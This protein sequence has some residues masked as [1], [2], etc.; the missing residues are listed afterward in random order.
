MSPTDSSLSTSSEINIDPNEEINIVLA[1]DH[2]LVQDGIR[3]RLEEIQGLN[4]IGMAD[5]GEDLIKIAEDLK[6]DIV[7]TDISMPKINGLEATR[8]LTQKQPQIKILILT[9]HDNKEYMQNAIDS[10]AHGYMLKDQPAGEMI[11]A[12]KNLYKGEKH[13]CSSATKVINNEQDKSKNSPVANR[14]F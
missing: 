4:V 14:Q 3:T 12:V 5:N 9:M 7:I 6:P 1:D 2:P 11:E 8:L 13:F 10:G